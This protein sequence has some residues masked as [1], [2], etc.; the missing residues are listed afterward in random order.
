MSGWRQGRSTGCKQTSPCV[1]PAAS[2]RSRAEERVSSRV[3]R[4]LRGR[5]RRGEAERLWAPPADSGESAERSW[6]GSSRTFLAAGS[7]PC[8]SVPHASRGQS[9]DTNRKVLEVW[10][11]EPTCVATRRGARGGT[12]GAGSRACWRQGPWDAL[13]SFKREKQP[14][15]SHAR[16]RR[17]PSES[18]ARRGHT[19]GDW[20]Q[21]CV[22][23]P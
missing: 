21:P 8:C 7:C 11:L 14:R 2:P 19:G 18:G 23:G 1:T 3:L 6:S 15:A 12:D 20:G 5:G 9:G 22:L 10:R 17:R 16:R 13:T 4:R